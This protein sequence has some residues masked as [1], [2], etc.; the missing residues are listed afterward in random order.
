VQRDELIAAYQDRFIDMLGMHRAL[1]GAGLEAAFRAT[2]RHRFVHHYYDVRRPKP[3]MV[4]VDPGRPSAA[5]LER[6]YSNDALATHR[7]PDP[8]STISQPSLVGQMLGLLRLEAGMNVLEVGA[9]TG[10]VAALIGRLVGPTGS[11]TGIE[12]HAPVARA[13]RRAVAAA[14]PD[15]VTVITGDGALGHPKAAPF[16]RIIMSV[17]APE[18]FG[19]WVDQLKDGGLLLLPLQAMP[20]AAFCL[21]VA[22]RKSG[23][24]LAGDVVSP[25]WFVRFGGTRGV[26]DGGE[27]RTRELLRQANGAPKRRK[28]LAPWACVSSEA[29]RFYRA[30]LLFMAYLEGMRVVQDDKAILLT[31]PRSEGFCLLEDAH[32]QVMGDEAIYDELIAVARRWLALGAPGAE[33]YRLEVWP[34]RARKRAPR[35]GWLVRR[36][37]SLLLFRL[38]RRR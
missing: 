20:H 7:P 25:A 18:V 13:A 34:E 27:G 2:P 32:V 33:S 5:Q 10:W 22:L 30:K 17:G 9:G 24:H 8:L 37:E 6:I 35:D 12:L 29:R 16:D 23:E 26:D 3:R 15:N 36:D 14:G 1:E 38:K 4:T 31:S 21:L 19:T 11:V 28:R